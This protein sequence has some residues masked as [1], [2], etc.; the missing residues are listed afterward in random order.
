M[1]IK[2]DH[3]GQG[4]DIPYKCKYCGGRYCPDHRLP[5]GH[6]CDGVE[7]LSA[8]GKRFETK[9]GEVVNSGDGIKTPEPMEIEKTVGNTPDVGYEKSPPVKVKSD[10][11]ETRRKE[12]GP[13]LLSFSIVSAIKRLLPF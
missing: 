3:C 5:E 7:F 1:G 8:T 10:Q 13:P 4:T 12:S 9:T 6:S 11:E 2:C